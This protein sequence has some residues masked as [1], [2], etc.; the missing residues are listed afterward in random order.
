M[1]CTGAHAPNNTPSVPTFMA[2]LSSTCKL[3]ELEIRA[4]HR[5][6]QGQAGL[7]GD[8]DGQRTLIQS[9]AQDGGDAL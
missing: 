8:G 9:A 7:C 6:V 4:A 3:F 5:P 1:F 2:H